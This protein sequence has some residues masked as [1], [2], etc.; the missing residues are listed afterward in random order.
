MMRK[1]MIF[2]DITTD[3]ENT[4]TLKENERCLFFMLNRSGEIRFELAGS[5]AEAHI[6]AFFIGKGAD[7]ATLKTSQIHSA[8]RTLSQALIKS[9]LFDAAVFTYDGLIHIEKN[10]PQTDAS[11][12]SRALLLSPRAQAF[13][14]PTLEILAN[15]VKCR[16]A[17]TVSPLDAEQ[18]FFAQSRGLSHQ[19]AEQL[20]IRG[21]FKDALEKMADLGAD[22]SEISRN[23]ATQLQ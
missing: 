5:G 16:H 12:E 8:P 20:L 7:A 1:T 17:A 21:F 10:A 19:Q 13:A 18:L 2:K 14:K 3:T 4:Y 22:T 15:D 9:V 23:I 11:Q 6:F